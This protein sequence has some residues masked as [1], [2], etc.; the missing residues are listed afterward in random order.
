MAKH[1][2]LARRLAALKAMFVQS[3]RGMSSAEHAMTLSG[4]APATLYFSD[5]PQRVAGHLS[6]ARFVELWQHGQNSFAVDPPNAVLSFFSDLADAPDNAT[7]T[8]R[9][10]RL[11]GDD[12]TYDVEVIEGTLPVRAAACSLFIDP[13]G[14]VI[15]IDAARERDEARLGSIAQFLKAIVAVAAGGPDR[16]EL[17][18]R[19]LAAAQQYMGAVGG[20]VYELD[21][22]AAVLR[23]LAAFGPDELVALYS[24]TPLD[25]VYVIAKVALQGELLT[26]ETD[27]PSEQ[28]LRRAAG[29]GLAEMGRISVPITVAGE[30]FGCYTLLFPTQQHISRARLAALPGGRRRARHRA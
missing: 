24:E 2:E 18:R 17:A 30:T 19:T 26:H 23:A 8:L 21:R 7:V 29:T 5:R 27:D 20:A 12:L 4:L 14:A 25:D 3:A 9:A 10:P 28:A 11:A 13:A 15:D 22:E 6:S 16:A 1:D